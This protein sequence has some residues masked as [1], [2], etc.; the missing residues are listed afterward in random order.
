MENAGGKGKWRLLSGKDAG[1]PNVRKERGKEQA[2]KK[3]E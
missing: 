1:M 2:V 3:A